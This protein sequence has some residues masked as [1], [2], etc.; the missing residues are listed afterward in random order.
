MTKEHIGAKWWKF[1]FHTHTPAS[2]DYGKGPNQATLKNRTP[3]EWLIDYMEQGIDCICVTDYNSAEWIDRLRVT[4]RQMEECGHPSYRPITIFPGVEI[5]VNG[6][7]HVLAIFDIAVPQQTIDILLTVCGF[8]GTKGASDDVTS[9]SLIDVVNTI[10]KHGGLAIP[11]HVD[12]FSGIFYAGT[13]GQPLVAGQTLSK[14]LKECDIA[15][16]EIIDV[17]VAKPQAYIEQN[18]MHAEVLGSD[19][20]HPSGVPGSRFPGSHYTWCKMGRPDLD[21]LRLALL[22]GHH[23]IKRSDSGGTDPNDHGKDF[24]TYLEVADAK[25]MGRGKF[26]PFRIEFSPWM[27]SIIGGRGT[28]KSTILEFIRLTTGRRD[29]VPPALHNELRKYQTTSESRQDVGLLRPS[30]TIEIGY[31]KDTTDYRVRWSAGTNTHTIERKQLDDSWAAEEGIVVDRFPIRI[32]SQ[33]QIFELAGAPKALLDLIDQSP[34]VDYREWDEKNRELIAHLSL[35]RARKKELQLQIDDK[36]LLKGRL[37]DLLRRR[38]TYEKERHAEVLVE[39]HNKTKQE[40]AVKRWEISWKH[41]SKVVRETTA[42]FPSDL[43]LPTMS[44]GCI[45]AGT[46]INRNSINVMQRLIAIRNSVDKAADDL[47]KLWEEWSHV[48]AGSSWN[49]DVQATYQ[50][51]FENGLLS[52]NGCGGSSGCGPER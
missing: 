29:E 8:S 28:G 15:A 44:E 50:S 36:I 12:T 30:T 4:L 42:N 51:L 43:S 22:D 39:Y 26:C 19:A 10:N 33:K 23:S 37:N 7:I 6:G 9:S 16:L 17:D 34:E 41:L 48:K 18:V 2:T 32:F 14:F 46:E 20:H 25:F 35:L 52:Q 40:G 27:T 45:D 1:E 11:A 5:S 31:R 38:E 47:E 21:G 49:N 24:I 13:S 3:E